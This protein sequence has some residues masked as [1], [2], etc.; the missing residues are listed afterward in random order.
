VT[1]PAGSPTIRPHR[2]EAARWCTAGVA[3][4]V[5]GIL[6]RLLPVLHGGGLGSNLGYDP[7]VYFAAADGLVHGRLP[8]RDF[9]LLHPPG[10]MLVLSPFALA[11]RWVSDQAAF[12]SANLAFTCLGAFNAVFVVLIGRRLAL[13]LGAATGGGLFA[14]LWLG[15]VHAEDMARLEPLANLLVLVAL[16]GY[17]VARRRPSGRWMFVMGAAL[18]GATSVKIWYGVLLIV[19]IGWVAGHV[20]TR[21]AVLVAVSGA[22]AA[23]VAINGFFFLKAPGAMWRMIVIDQLGRGRF[24]ASP[25]TRFDQANDVTTWNRLLGPGPTAAAIAVL[26]LGTA[27]LLRA[28]WRQPAGRVL[29]VIVAVQVVVMAVSPSWFAFY[30]DYLTPA[31]ALAV[32][33]GVDGVRT[34]GWTTIRALRHPRALAWAGLT[35]ASVLVVVLAVPLSWQRAG[36]PFPSAALAGSVRDSPCVVADSPMALIELGA[37]SRSFSPGCQDWV[38]VVGRTYGADRS[39]DSRPDNV[40]WE[41]DLSRYLLSGDAFIV[42]RSSTGLSAGTARELGRRTVIARAG[43]FVIYRGRSALG[44]TGAGRGQ[45]TPGT[46]GR[47]LGAPVNRLQR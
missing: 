34:A 16:Y 22:A 18:G 42:I 46:R 23:M 19:L 24:A 4:F 39:D 1:S 32:A 43:R 10:L 47:G 20:R 30:A 27:V 3:V 5:V 28:A 12:I 17:A 38:D 8:Y 11:T 35:A 33:V 44:R 9:V 6:A 45:S 14:A 36:T 21:R 41:R 2:S 37:L 31:L 26:V 13:S 15:S 25:I 7:G 29:V 40:A